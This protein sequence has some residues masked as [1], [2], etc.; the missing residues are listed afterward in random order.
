MKEAGRERRQGVEGGGKHSSLYSC[1]HKVG[2]C[3]SPVLTHCW[4]VDI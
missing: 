1:R 3:T 4:L 2:V